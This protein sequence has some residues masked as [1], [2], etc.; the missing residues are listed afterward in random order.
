[1]NKGINLK[2]NGLQYSYICMYLYISYINSQYSLYM[3]PRAHSRLLA[4][5]QLPVSGNERGASESYTTTRYPLECQTLFDICLIIFFCQP[6][7]KF[8]C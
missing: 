5:V 8:M 2:E 3:R 1:M 6:E 4:R 7:N